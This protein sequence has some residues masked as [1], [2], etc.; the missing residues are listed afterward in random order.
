MVKS[1]MN[2]KPELETEAGSPPKTP[3]RLPWHAP[4][5]IV[6][7]LGCTDAMCNAGNDGRNSNPSL[8]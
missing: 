5:F 4:K 3:A 2:E 7:D 1:R 8:S 6:S